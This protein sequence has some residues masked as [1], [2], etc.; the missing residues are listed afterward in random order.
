MT[1]AL[2]RE[3]STLIGCQHAHDALYEAAVSGAE[4]A[5]GRPPKSLT[6]IKHCFMQSLGVTPV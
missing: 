3:I 1:E 5:T 2:V 4:R 6:C